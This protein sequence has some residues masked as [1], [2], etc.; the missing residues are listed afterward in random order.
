MLLLVRTV[1]KQGVGKRT[2]GLSVF[3][4]DMQEA[5]GNGLTI[6]PIRTMIDHAATETFF[7]DLEVPAEN[8]PGEEGRGSGH[9]PESMNAG[10]RAATE[11]RH[12]LRH[13]RTRGG[14]GRHGRECPPAGPWRRGT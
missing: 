14:R 1:P 6:R 7:D 5:P 13:R 9:V 3:V 8:L 10:T 12:P 4:V 11:G 2:E